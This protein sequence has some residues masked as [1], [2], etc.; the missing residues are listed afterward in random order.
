MVLDRDLV[1]DCQALGTWAMTA[2]Y[3]PSFLS[4]KETSTAR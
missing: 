1:E 2:A 4:G 3:A